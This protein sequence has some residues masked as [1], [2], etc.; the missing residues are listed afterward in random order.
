M[1]SS[2]KNRVT[3]WFRL[4][5]GPIITV[6]MRTMRLGK[7]LTAMAWA[8]FRWVIDNMLEEK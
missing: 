7:F 4:F 1:G 3:W 8:A 2:G 5:G 6:I